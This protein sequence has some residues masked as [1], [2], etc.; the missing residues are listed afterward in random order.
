MDQFPR[1]LAIP[2]FAQEK[3]LLKIHDPLLIFKLSGDLDI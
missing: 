3:T 2:R 1:A